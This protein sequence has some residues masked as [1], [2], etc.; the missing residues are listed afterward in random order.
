MITLISTVEVSRIPWLEQFVAHYHGLGVERF[1][2]SVQIEPTV[3]FEQSQKF[4]RHAQQILGQ[5]GVELVETIRCQFDAMALRQHHDELQ[6]SICSPDDW[7]IWAD[8]DELHGYQA[9]LPSLTRHW[10]TMGYDVVNGQF[11]DRVAEGG[12]LRKFDRRKPLWDQF[13]IGCNI[14]EKVLQGQTKKVCCARARVGIKYANHDVL[15]SQ[16]L[17]WADTVIGVHHFKWDATVTRR[18]RRRIRTSWRSRCPWWLQS[19]RAI[20]HIRKNKGRINLAE[21]DLIELEKF[22]S[23]V[24]YAKAASSTD[25][26][27]HAGI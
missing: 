3:C 7:V 19:S 16:R 17:S 15:K 18:L 5:F 4:S 25:G 11:I 6:H 2:I 26:S 14:T 9:D 22:F 20:G 24:R 12:V 27:I 21:L 1:L 8:I 13:P 23:G 10:A